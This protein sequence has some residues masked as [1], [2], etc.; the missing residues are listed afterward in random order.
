ML[1]LLRLAVLPFAGAAEALRQG[2]STGLEMDEGETAAKDSEKM[3]KRS[4][5][6]VYRHQGVLEEDEQ[7]HKPLLLP[8]LLLPFLS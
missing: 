3:M 2:G 5:V 8:L 7:P 1:L 6:E 4:A